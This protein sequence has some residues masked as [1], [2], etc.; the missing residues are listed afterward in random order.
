MDKFS[1]YSIECNSRESNM[2]ENI[3]K[4]IISLSN[5]KIS[6]HWGVDRMKIPI[7]AVLL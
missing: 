7:L 3:P 5:L 2:C 1:Y 4:F 6:L